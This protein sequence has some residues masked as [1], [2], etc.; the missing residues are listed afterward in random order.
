MG[1]S[2][3]PI[4]RSMST[5]TTGTI[6][7]LL[8]QPIPDM[9][10]NPYFPEFIEGIGKV[11]TTSGLSLMLVPPLMGSVR[12]AIVNAAVDGFLT[13]GLEEHKSTMM[14]LRQ[15]HVPFVT[16]DSDPIEGI[17]GVNVDDAGGAKKAMEHLLAQGHRAI[18]ILAIRSGKRG[19]Y[20]EYVG[21]LGARVQGYLQ[22]LLEYGLSIDS[23]HIKLTECEN[24]EKGGVDCFQKIWRA[25]QHPT[26]I[27]AMS[28]I[29]A[30]GVIKAAHAVEIQ[31][32]Q[33]LSIIGFDDIPLASLLTPALTTVAQPSIQKGLLAANTLV[34]MIA[35]SIKPVHHC[36]P[37]DLVLRKTVSVPPRAK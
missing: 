13:L 17:P 33:D 1:Y 6:G 26:A 20:E 22:A 19:N 3:D 18:H 35:G 9:M 32:P 31:I 15:R 14:V 37:T 7:L 24:T 34:R 11:C 29:I 27:L 36:L 25:R 2:P 10:R 12:R 23:R 30:I 16:I 4:A 8:P 21:T 5:G 28:D